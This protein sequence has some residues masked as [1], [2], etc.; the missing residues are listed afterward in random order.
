[1]LSLAIITFLATF[2]I[3]ETPLVT[4]NDKLQHLAS[5]VWLAF[6]LD[7]S[8]PK[9]AF[10]PGKFISLLGYGIALEAIQHHLPYREFSISDIIAD[11]FGLIGYALIQG[12]LTTLNMFNYRRTP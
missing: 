10:T 6:F 12:R 8:F 9:T 2:D 5:F 3:T 11:G 7:F 1:M 4:I